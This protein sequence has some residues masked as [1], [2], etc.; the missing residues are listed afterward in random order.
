MTD[1]RRHALATLGAWAAPDPS[2]EELRAAYVTHLTHHTDALSRSCLPDHI[3]ASTLVLSA[4]GEH[5]LLTLHAKAGQWF[6]LGGHVE[7][8]DA[9]LQE[10]ALREATEESGVTGLD[11]D[12]VPVHL[13]AHVVPFCGGRS[14]TRHLDVRFLAVAPH[15]G[16]HRVSEESMDVRWWPVAA[17]PT[18][19]PSLLRL[20]ELGRHRLGL[21]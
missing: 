20:V 8:G 14:D 19:E 5:T 9:T 6:Q 21:Y 15:G 1:L 18:Q 12:P 2:Q 3:T 16:V 13:D 7:P 4:D 17:L 10:A 11:L